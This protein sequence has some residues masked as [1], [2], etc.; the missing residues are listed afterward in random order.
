[1]RWKTL[2]PH[3]VFNVWGSY[4]YEHGFF[5]RTAMISMRF[6]YKVIQ[7]QSTIKNILNSFYFIINCFPIKIISFSRTDNITIITGKFLKICGMHKKFRIKSSGSWRKHLKR[8]QRK[9]KNWMSR[10][11]EN[12]LVFIYNFLFL[13]KYIAWIKVL[14]L[15]GTY[16]F[17]QRR[18]ILNTLSY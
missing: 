7:V 1:M 12:K 18:C 10:N 16:Y 6:N 3:R 9:K 11:V 14:M 13:Y 17:L 15:Y 2:G 5:L 8:S 4:L